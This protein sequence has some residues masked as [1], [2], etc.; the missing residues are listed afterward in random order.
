MAEQ[1][2]IYKANLN[3]TEKI[4]E[5]LE[6]FYNSREQQRAIDNAAATASKF[7]I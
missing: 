4:K 6:L 2:N 7:K 3:A 5:Q 1:A